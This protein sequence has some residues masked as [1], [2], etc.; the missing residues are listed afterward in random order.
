MAGISSEEI[1]LEAALNV[2]DKN[3]I[4]KTRMHLIAEEANMSAANLHYHFKTKQELLVALIQ[5]LEKKFSE[6]REDTFK[7][8]AN[9]LESQVNGFFRQKK[10]LLENGQKYDR[11]QMD[12]WS[13]G[14]VDEEI[15]GY[16]R[17]TLDRWRNHMRQVITSHRPEISKEQQDVVAGTMV[18]LM[19]GATLQYL[20]GEA[21]F[22]LDAYFKACWKMVMT[23]IINI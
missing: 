17:E 22:D 2:I 7:Y 16:F 20:N 14:Q 13:L 15:N 11:V 19:M 5:Y 18:S 1:I 8:V 10:E 6:F 21:P 23:Y 9:D 4:S 12:F 3:T